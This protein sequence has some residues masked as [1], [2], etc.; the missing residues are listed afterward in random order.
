MPLQKN[1][2]MVEEEEG[3]EMV[4]APWEDM[5]A[6]G[7]GAG[8]A[9]E[10]GDED[11]RD[12]SADDDDEDADD[13]RAQASRKKAKVEGGGGGGGGGDGDGEGDV[14]EDDG[15]AAKK[16]RRARRMSGSSAGR[17]RRS[18]FAREETE[19]ERAARGVP[20]DDVI[21]HLERRTQ[22]AQL[23]VDFLVYI[24]FLILFIF[25][26]HREITANY[27]VVRAVQDQL[28][29]NELPTEEIDKRFGDLANAHDWGRWAT[30]V[31]VPNIWACK[32]SDKQYE[33]IDAQGKN[34]LIGALRV[35]T[36]RVAPDS[37]SVSSRFFPNRPDMACY[38]GWSNGAE[39]TVDRWN[40][41]SPVLYPNHTLV[42]SDMDELEYRV[43]WPLGSGGSGGSSGSSGGSPAM[44]AGISIRAANGTL[45]P[46]SAYDLYFTDAGSSGSSSSTFAPYT[47]GGD[48]R[49]TSL[50]AVLKNPPPGSRLSGYTFEAV[51]DPPTNLHNPEAW[52]VHT[53][54]YP[55]PAAAAGVAAAVAAASW[56]LQD[57]ELD[58]PVGEWTGAGGQETGGSTER[59]LRGGVSGTT[60]AL[61]V[62]VRRVVHESLRDS[63]EKPFLYRNRRCAHGGL[64]GWIY[65]DV[66]LYHCGGYSVDIPFSASCRTAEDLTK[67]LQSNNYPFYDVYATRLMVTEMFIYT[68]NTNSFTSVKLFNEVAATGG[69]VNKW[70]IRTFMVYDGEELRMVLDVL[71]LVFMVYFYV[72]FVTD[73][74][75]YYRGHNPGNYETKGKILG[76]ILQFWT[77]LEFA[78]LVCF[79][80]VFVVEFLWIAESN[81]KSVRF[82]YPDEYPVD[83]DWLLN[84][85]MLK[86]N[87]NAV[88]MIIT[89]LK[90]L[91]Y[92]RLNA[93]LNVLSATIACKAWD[94]LGCLLIFVYFVFAYSLTA[95]ALFGAT[96]HDYR[97]IAESYSTLMRML[98]GDFDFESLRQESI[99]LA[100]V[101]FWSFIVIA[102]FLL[103]NFVVA[104]LSEGF[105]EVS[106]D[107]SQVPVD[108]QFQKLWTAVKK[109]LHPRRLLQGAQ[110][111]LRGNSRHSLLLRATE[112]MHEYRS[113]MHELSGQEA[114][115]SRPSARPAPSPPATTSP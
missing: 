32:F 104:I 43:D 95:N 85:Y 90:F 70:Q 105:A 14:E 11:D 87:A 38:A 106:G 77:I 107:I 37:C 27:Y 34:L 42:Q 92:V 13:F 110:M 57:E 114:A 84:I 67:A 71:F 4:D 75:S 10:G 41:P 108:E 46:A 93:R 33:R 5:A 36:L 53:T 65:G 80:F 18:S 59:S 66:D 3:V 17:R 50:V 39:E 56:S 98:L 103:L 29:G 20:I 7:G 35:R 54:S 89:F 91:K 68:P 48:E 16:A 45:L 8:R 52:E 109:M 55:M 102:L 101:F 9:A 79:F 82:P 112:R 99:Y 73:W 69:W 25:F 2:R 44:L 49:F 64:V 21:G 6:G 83:L 113:V 26:S 58:F 61:R 86:V 15:D 81:K 115:V 40:F 63:P 72:R 60:T 1:V 111:T 100:A 47:G 31:M 51:S 88:N 94:L 24:P 78:N 96:L 76:Y 97:T 30:Y 23:Y 22:S 12:N 62:S 28:M 19:A 74:I